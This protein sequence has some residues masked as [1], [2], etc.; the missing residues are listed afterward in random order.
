LAP[1]TP[2]PPRPWARNASGGDG[3]D[4]ALGRHGD[5]EVLVV[6]EVL[7][8][9]VAGVVVDASCAGRGVLLADLAQLVLDDVGACTVVGEDRL[10][11]G[12]GLAQLLH[13][14]LELGATEPGEAVEA[15]CRGCT[16]GL[17]LGELEA[18][19]HAAR[20][21]A[22]RDGRPRRGWWR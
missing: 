11:L 6:D 10:E 8:V 12:D 13:L 5:D 17:D 15:A 19:A 4:V 18:L 9:D 22:A 21:S 2:R 16:V 3:L 7:D 1:A 14:L 20:R